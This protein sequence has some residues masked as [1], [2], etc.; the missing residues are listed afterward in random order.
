MT[1]PTASALDDVVLDAW[2]DSI[3]L[4]L[5]LLFDIQPMQLQQLNSRQKVAS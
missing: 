3:L 2:L 1:V 5:L 4:L